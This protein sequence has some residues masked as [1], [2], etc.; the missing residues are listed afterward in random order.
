MDVL[1]KTFGNQKSEFYQRYGANL[2]L[3]FSYSA[4]F[5]AHLHL[6]LP[7]EQIINDVQALGGIL[8]DALLDSFASSCM[9]A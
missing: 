4:L 8:L 7:P 5:K 9:F 1:V 3:F 6:N 2:T